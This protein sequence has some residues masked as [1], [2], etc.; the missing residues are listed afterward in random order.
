[1]TIVILPAAARKCD[2]FW[3]VDLPLYE[4]KD[5]PPQEGPR[6]GKKKYTSYY[7]STLEHAQAQGGTHRDHATHEHARTRA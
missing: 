6:G 7:T 1:M 2:D 5:P 4:L 3:I